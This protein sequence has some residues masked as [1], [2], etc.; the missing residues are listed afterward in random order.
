M[1]SRGQ[2]ESE[3]F[4]IDV[5]TSD[6][7]ANEENYQDHIDHDDNDVDKPRGVFEAVIETSTI[8]TTVVENSVV[9]RRGRLR[10]QSI[11]T[12]S[13]KIWLKS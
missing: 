6:E 4:G 10:K 1:D 7:K 2:F 12:N 9:K 11:G 8:N 13:R 5:D 3:R